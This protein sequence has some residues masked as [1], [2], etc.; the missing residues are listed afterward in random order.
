MVGAVAVNANKPLAPLTVGGPPKSEAARQQLLVWRAD[1][2]RFAHDVLGFTPDRW[3]EIVLRAVV[4]DRR[5]AMI[6][7]KGPGKSALLAVIIWWWMLTRRHAQV[8]CTSISRENLR[9][10][11]WKE[12]SF[13][14]SK[15][16]VLQAA[17]EFGKERI[18]AKGSPEERANWWVSARGW[19]Q[20]AD[21]HSQAATLAGLHGPAMMY[22]GDEAGDYPPGVLAAA[23]AVLA[24]V[25]DANEG[26]VIV[27]GNPTSTAGPLYA[28]S[29]HNRK[30]WHVTHITGDP[31]DPLRSSRIDIKWAR[32]TIEQYG[33][34][35]PYVLVNIFGK[36]P[37]TGMNQLI[38]PDLVREAMTRAPRPPD[39][40]YSQ[41][42]L[43]IDVARFGDDSTV[44]C[45]RQGL[46]CFPPIVLR[47]A[48]TN[49]VAGRVMNVKHKWGSELEAIDGTGG[50]GAGVVDALIQAGY[51]PIEKNFAGKSQDPVF[52]NAR[53][54]MWWRMVEWIKRGGALPDDPELARDL[55]VPMYAHKGGK[56]QLEEKEQIKKRLGYS[57]DR[58]DAL[59]LTFAIP[60]AP[61][62]RDSAT[63]AIRP[64]NEIG[65]VVVSEWDPHDPA[66]R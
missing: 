47:G 1:P 42:R 58:A 31:D 40:M 35:N 53:T 33:R 8:V 4:K 64:D 32:E 65:N 49:E 24:N 11:L 61:G 7:C 48:D 62:T 66:R 52:F 28:I 39:Y 14:F 10:G 29:T 55:T 26:R 22:V 2:V 5:V 44:I 21:Q 12:L 41:K 20:D 54:E 25:N 16:K 19:A 45:P 36:F 60:E 3:Q 27:A 56:I 46:V 43:G 38:G 23:D 63:G 13:W 15:S 18:E 57:P 51:S 50:Y 9:D 30:L 59:A 6:A 17:F 37:P 34:E